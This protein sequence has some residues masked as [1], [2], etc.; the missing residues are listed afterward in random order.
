MWR[1]VLQGCIQ[2]ITNFVLIVLVLVT[3]VSMNPIAQV[4]S[5]AQVIWLVGNAWMLETVQLAPMLM[6]QPWNVWLVLLDVVYVQVLLSALN[7]QEYISSMKI[8]ASHHALQAL[9]KR[10]QFAKIVRLPVPLASTRPLIAYPVKITPYS[11][12]IHALALVL[13]PLI[14]PV[15]IVISVCPHA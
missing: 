4:A 14:T 9:I 3:P 11:I 5:T 10:G 6:P 12:R 7:A 2:K 1:T 13:T 8:N 15:E